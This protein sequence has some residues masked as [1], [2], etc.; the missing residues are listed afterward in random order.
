VAANQPGWRACAGC[1]VALAFIALMVGGMAYVIVDERSKDKKV[2]AEP[3]L[4]IDADELAKAYNDD[5]NSAHGTYDHKVLLV[6]GK[7]Q[8]IH[9]SKVVLGVT[10]PRSPVWCDIEN[11]SRDKARALKKGQMVTIKGYCEGDKA[12]S[13]EVKHCQIPD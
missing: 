8:D 11:E 10:F 5:L 7:V 1:L 6:T 12:F 9:G 13:I 4:A 2:A 3:G